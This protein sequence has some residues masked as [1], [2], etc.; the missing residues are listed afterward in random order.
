MA[1]ATPPST[2]S[3]SEVFGHDPHHHPS[4]R[5]AMGHRL[6]MNAFIVLFLLLLFAGFVNYFLSLMK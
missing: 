4:G 5:L 6:A 2:S 3:T 1:K